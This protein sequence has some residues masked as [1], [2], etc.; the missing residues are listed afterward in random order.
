MIENSPY[1]GVKFGVQGLNFKTLGKWPTQSDS[2]NC[3]TITSELVGFLNRLYLKNGFRDIKD[4]S[5]SIRASLNLNTNFP[6]NFRYVKPTEMRVKMFHEVTDLD[7]DH[8]WTRWDPEI[9]LS[10][11]TTTPTVPP[12]ENHDHPELE[13]S[14]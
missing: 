7:A 12:P 4:N 5:L 14:E 2:W 13:V 10:G 9:W 11:S 8:S 3:G 6:Q 1:C